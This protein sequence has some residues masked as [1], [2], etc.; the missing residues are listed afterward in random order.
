MVCLKWCRK[1]GE[2][3]SCF[4]G[5]DSYNSDSRIASGT[6]EAWGFSPRNSADWFLDS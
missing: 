2:V 1:E 6:V 3:Q 5:D 4:F